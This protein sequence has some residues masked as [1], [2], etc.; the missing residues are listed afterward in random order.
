MEALNESNPN[1]QFDLDPSDEGDFNKLMVM[2]P[3]SV[4]A[5]PHGF[6]IVG[7]DNA[8]MDPLDLSRVAKDILE[9]VISVMP[10]PVELIV[11]PSCLLQPRHSSLTCRAW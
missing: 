10:S 7:V 4:K 8:H 9:S 11:P 5:F 1:L 6:Q 3:S 2:L